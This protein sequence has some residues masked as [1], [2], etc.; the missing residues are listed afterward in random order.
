MVIF[1]LFILIRFKTLAK[2]AEEKYHFE[3]QIAESEMRVLR[4]QANPHFI[5]NALNSIRYFILKNEMNQAEFYLQRFAHLMRGVL[6]NSKKE[7]IGLDKE[8]EYLQTYIDLE[9]VRLRNI[10][11][12]NISIPQNGMVDKIFIPTMLLQP[13]VE[14]AIWH[15]LT[16]LQERPGKID[17]HVEST[18]SH[19]LIIVSDN[20]IGRKKSVE[21]KNGRTQLKK[22]FGISIVNERI[23]L[24]NK[25]H[26][27][28]ITIQIIDLIDENNMPIGTRVE[29]K[30][31]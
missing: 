13:F 3:I 31:K 11:S 20:G 7:L 8:M 14:N 5:F 30:L 15:G 18:V 29:L 21:L 22:S 16:T 10:F 19:T 4:A 17:I 12:Y 1:Y 23:H 25:Q 2:R 6:E 9:R 27:E 28:K 26:K 24:F